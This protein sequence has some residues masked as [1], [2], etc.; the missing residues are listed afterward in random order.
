MQP[1]GESPALEAKSSHIP[2]RNCEN[3][4]E[5]CGGYGFFVRC[6]ECAGNGFTL[7]RDE[8]RTFSAPSCRPCNG[9][10]MLFAFPENTA[11]AS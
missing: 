9:T 5:E 6:R 10:G 3:G 8:D 4:C 7:E 11:V 2:C 1:A